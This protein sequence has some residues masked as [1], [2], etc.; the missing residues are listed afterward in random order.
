MN[1]LDL[2]I[3][4]PTYN[5]IDALR[6]LL[7][8]LSEQTV[9]AER[10]EVI[11]IDDGS[12][13]PVTL[14]PHRYPFA[15]HLHRQENAG[16]AAARN[17]GIAQAQAPLTL[18]LNDDGIA[19]SDLLEVHLRV[20]A[21]RN[22]KVAVLGQFPFTE[23]LLT[24]PF[25]QVLDASDL[26]FPHRYLTAGELHG[27]GF[28][29]TCNISLPTAALRTVGGFDDKNFRQAICEDVE[30][31][32]RLAYE[33]YKV[34]YIPEAKCEHEHYIS[35]AAY[36]RRARKLGVNTAKMAEIHG[37]HLLNFK[38]WNTLG[39]Q[40]TLAEIEEMYWNK[41]HLYEHALPHA[42]TIFVQVERIER[43]GI[44]PGLK[45]LNQLMDGI[46]LLNWVYY[47]E[48]VLA[49]FNARYH[50]EQPQRVAL[51]IA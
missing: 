35:P 27:P 50:F 17:V 7:R 23:H 10:F 26:L 32:F 38:E 5:R 18:I 3:I 45:A 24:S 29:W 28:F 34:L 9:S 1:S 46:H 47:L 40:Y 42:Q 20:H 19:A 15:L 14:D 30:I 6:N 13:M 39:A 11:V 33:G 49:E 44:A 4:I 8:S 36:V 31:G 16:P 25:M 22:D 37:W 12:A 21:E 41:K 43:D 51:R 48:G 2:S